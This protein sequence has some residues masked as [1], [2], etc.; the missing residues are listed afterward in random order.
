M[1]IRILSI[2]LSGILCQAA[3]QDKNSFVGFNTG[4]SIPVGKYHE[5]SLGEPSGSFATTG[6]N[7]A[8]EGA[9]FFKPWIGIGGQ[10]AIDFH[11]VD[12]WTLGYEIVQETPELNDL[13]IR[14]EPYRNYAFYAG[15][16]FE[17][18]VIRNF[19]LTA[20]ALGG[21]LYSQTPYQL[22]K[23]D[24]YLIGEKWYDKTRAGDMEGSFLAGAGLKYYLPNCLALT[25]NGE[26]TWNKAEFNFMVADGS[27]RTD[28][29]I[30]SFVNIAAGIIVVL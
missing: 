19:S 2:I 16:F 29:H 14:S 12:V 23:A 10:A 6:F 9:W 25:L 22:F 26:F 20:K 28:E 27:I 1:K 24:Y 11:P 17:K 13:Y 7:A 4:L 18:P 15:I 30:I 21:F 8:I 5:K 3:G